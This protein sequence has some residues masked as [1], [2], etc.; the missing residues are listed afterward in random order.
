MHQPGDYVVGAA[1]HTKAAY[2]ESG[3]KT[4]NA[5]NGIVG[6]AD[7][8]E[9]IKRSMLNSGAELLPT[10]NTPAAPEVKKRG[11]KKMSATAPAPALAQT[12]T[13]PDMSVIKPLPEPVTQ[14]IIPAPA[15]DV[16]FKNNFGKIMVSVEQVLEEELA[17]GLV[18]SSEREIRFIPNPVEEVEISVAGQPFIKVTFSG[19]IFTWLDHTKKI[20]VLI[21]TQTPD[22]EN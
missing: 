15:I 9:K 1:D 3:A 20:M 6:S 19:I 21:R 12:I 10:V 11:R 8:T 14:N 7:M 18:F 16:V 22:P 5:I 13:I 4:T 17:L 2:T